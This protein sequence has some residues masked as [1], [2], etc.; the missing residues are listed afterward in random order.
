MNRL[1]AVGRMLLVLGS[2]KRT[3]KVSVAGS[4]KRE[5]SLTCDCCGEFL[6]EALPDATKPPGNAATIA[7][8]VIPFVTTWEMRIKNPPLHSK[9]EVVVRRIPQ[10]GTS[11]PC[12]VSI[13]IHC[14][15]LHANLVV[16]VGRS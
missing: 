12:Q 3:T 13:G 14:N 6:T 11:Y 10:L 8:R 5:N 1:E 4:T 2:V 15:A 16:D 9:P 7:R